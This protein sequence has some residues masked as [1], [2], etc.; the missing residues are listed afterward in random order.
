MSTTAV[1][2]EECH[3]RDELAELDPHDEECPVCLEIPSDEIVSANNGEGFKALSE[4]GHKVC[5]KC[6]KTMLCTNNYVQGLRCPLCRAVDNTSILLAQ[7]INREQLS[8]ARRAHENRRNIAR[9]Y[10]A[11]MAQENTNIR[12]QPSHATNQYER[13]LH[14]SA[15]RTLNRTRVISG[16]RVAI[17]QMTPIFCLR[18]DTPGCQTKNKT[19]RRCTNHPQTPCCSNCIVCNI[20]IDS[21]V[22]NPVH[23]E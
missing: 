9:L 19:K 6:V 17:P 8:A 1:A 14:Q 2:E 18:C 23:S 10:A 3:P 16:P 11:R 15:A 20:C 13:L 22:N 7:D 21:P 5:W 12:L 4:C